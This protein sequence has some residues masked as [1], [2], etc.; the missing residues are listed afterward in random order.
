MALNYSGVPWL[1]GQ[2][3]DSPPSPAMYQ[4]IRKIGQATKREMPLLSEPIGDIWGRITEQHQIIDAMLDDTPGA[5]VYL[6][7][8]FQT[9]LT[10]GFE[11]GHIDTSKL[12]ASEEN[13][14]SLLAIIMGKLVRLA[15]ALGCI[16]VANPE[17]GPQTIQYDQEYLLDLISQSVPFRYCPAIIPRRYFRARH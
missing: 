11:Q 6:S 14:Q 15:E 4:F 8:M 17:Q 12:Q 1:H 9:P 7:H 2:F 5:E 16:P 13:R 10:N 3:C